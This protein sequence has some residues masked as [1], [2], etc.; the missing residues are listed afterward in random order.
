MRAEVVRPVLRWHGGK[1]RLAPWIMR[2]FPRHLVYVEPFAGAASVLLQKPTLPA[3]V[4]NDLDGMVV[5]VFRVLRDPAK[6]AE[7]ERRLRLTLFARAEFEWSYQPAAD[8]ID[9]AH[10]TIVR[11]FMGFGSDSNTRS[12]RTGFRAKMSDERAFPS[13]A[14]ATYADAVPTFVR[15]LSTVLIEQRPALQVIGRYDSARTL[16]YVDP[17]Y[18]PET[19]SSLTG[20]SR[21]T[22][23]YTHE[24]NRQDHVR[25]L[26][27]L[28]RLKGMVVLSG[29]PSELYDSRLKHWDRVETIALAD[30]ARPRTEVLWLNPACVAALEQER[31]GR[32]TPL[33]PHMA[34]E[35]AT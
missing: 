11:G 24:L 32:G 35:L 31:A 17:P 27:A 1:F 7:L 15:R 20:R 10:R 34:M 3:E 29:Y 25:L 12:C 19:R 30:G 18:L 28:K 2:H 9:A 6:A 26:A 4:Y 13:Q 8:D 23:G 16:F 5:N 14:W 33:F 22:H 21:K